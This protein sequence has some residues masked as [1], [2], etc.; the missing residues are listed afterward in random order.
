MGI[1]DEQEILDTM[2]RA[3]RQRKSI[4][5]ADVFGDGRHVAY[6]DVFVKTLTTS[7]IWSWDMSLRISDTPRATTKIG[8]E[9]I[10]AVAVRDTRWKDDEDVHHRDALRERRHRHPPRLDVL[11]YTDKVG[12]HKNR[13]RQSKMIRILV[14]KSRICARL[15]VFTTHELLELQEVSNVG[16]D[17]GTPEDSG[18]L[19]S[20]QHLCVVDDA[21]LPHNL[22]LVL[23]ICQRVKADRGRWRTHDPQWGPQRHSSVALD[24][25]NHGHCRGVRWVVPGTNGWPFCAGP[26]KV[27]STSLSTSSLW[28]RWQPFAESSPHCRFSRLFFGHTNFFLTCCQ[29]SWSSDSK[30]KLEE[31]L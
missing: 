11:R 7:Q 24:R 31:M 10:V 1:R 22:W 25:W 13:L 6:D 18:P 4:V 5:K 9:R 8:L 26:V 28:L 3:K 16:Q 15:S 21:L 29:D 27:T 30:I 14:R 19:Q 12:P 20:L 23:K 17:H 2:S